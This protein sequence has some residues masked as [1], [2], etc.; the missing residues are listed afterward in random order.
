MTVG[1][2]DAALK[3]EGR[4]LA[5]A[6]QNYSWKSKLF[7]QV[8]FFLSIHSERGRWNCLKSC[9][10]LLQIIE[11]A[12]LEGKIETLSSI[13]VNSR[14]FPPTL[15]DEP[16]DIIMNN[17]KSEEVKWLKEGDVLECKQRDIRI[18]NSF[19]SNSRG[20]SPN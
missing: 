1:E 13:G 11:L 5:D 7:C 14:N 2:L 15:G 12:K 6:G 19:V 9:A 4:T 16:L 3:L 10:L 8:H 18:D 17:S 20:G